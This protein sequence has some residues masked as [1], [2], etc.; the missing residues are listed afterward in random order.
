MKVTIEGD[1]DQV[2]DAMSLSKPATISSRKMRL[3]E[4]A[5][6]RKI[7]RERRAEV[8]GAFQKVRHHP[9][10]RETAEA[11]LAA[12]RRLDGVT[13]DDLKIARSVGEFS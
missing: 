10:Q 2:A 7:F 12:L 1:L 9:E 8:V 3:A 5:A 13:D 4:N 6:K 11:L